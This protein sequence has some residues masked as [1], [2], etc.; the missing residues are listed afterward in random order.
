[1]KKSASIKITDIVYENK[2]YIV[3]VL[4]KADGYEFK[5]AYRIAPEHG[6][7]DVKTFKANLRRDIIEEIKIRK[8]IEPIEELKAKDFII[9]YDEGNS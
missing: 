5:K 9:E 4:V 3:G 7:V 1:M 6:T 8:S 2:I